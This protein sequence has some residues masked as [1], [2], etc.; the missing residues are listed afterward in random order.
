MFY[1]WSTQIIRSRYTVVETYIHMN[2]AINVYQYGRGGKYAYMF[3][4]TYAGMRDMK[5]QMET[6]DR[7]MSRVM[8]T[9]IGTVT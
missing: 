9:S 7:H 3:R 5:M 2:M 1:N 6:E 4:Y 8:R